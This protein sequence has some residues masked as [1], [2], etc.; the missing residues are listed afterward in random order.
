MIG[1]E[2]ATLGSEETNDFLHCS[3][4]LHRPHIIVVVVVESTMQHHVVLDVVEE[5]VPILSEYMHHAQLYADIRHGA[6]RLQSV[7]VNFPVRQIG[8]ERIEV[9]GANVVQDHAGNVG[10]V[11][12]DN[13]DAK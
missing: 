5:E 10:A 6:Q 11:F 4:D 9:G 7:P 1:C 3:W 12:A 13:L 8:S 2:H